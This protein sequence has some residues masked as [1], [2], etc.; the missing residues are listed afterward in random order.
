ML[1]LKKLK[2]MALDTVFVKGEIDN[3]PE[4][5][6]MTR[7]GGMLKWVAVRGGIHDWAIYCHY[8]THSWDY[9]KSNGD[10]VTQELHIKKLVPC[11]SKAFKIYRY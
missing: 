1:T 7:E 3:S 5:I 8:N 2:D 4:G 6:F 10:K 9:V 11:D